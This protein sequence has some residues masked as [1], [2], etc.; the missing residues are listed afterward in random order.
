[1]VTFGY[2]EIGGI[3][4]DKEIRGIGIGIGIGK[5]LPAAS[6]ACQP[7]KDSSDGPVHTA[8]PVVSQ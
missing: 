1:M 3:G 5:G 2:R 6:P 8:S 4:K 7:H